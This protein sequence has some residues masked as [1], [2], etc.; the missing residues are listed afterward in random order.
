MSRLQNKIAVITGSTRGFGYAL[1]AELL[2][3]GVKV[4]V[5]GRTQPAV[6]KA[7]EELRKLGVLE[8]LTCDVSVPEQVYAL[9]RFAA[10]KFGGLDIWVNNAGYTTAAGG[11]IDFPPEEALTTLE[12][13]CLGTLNG[14]Q[15]ALAVMLPRRQGTLV[16]LYGRGS[17]LKPASP[18]GLYGATKAWITSFTRTLAAENKGQGIQIVGFSPGMMR[19]SMLEVEEVVGER[20]QAMM[21]NMPMVYE[22]LA[23]PPQEPAAELV[24][25][26]E[27]NQKEFV[28]Y[29]YLRGLRG[30]AMI[31]QLVWMQMNPKARP[32]PA[33]YPHRPAFRPPVGPD[34]R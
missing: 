28:E 20:V 16:N 34:L 33:D 1:A 25:L 29:R 13:N 27:T 6:D 15:A 23:R 12:T 17:D 18:S 22:A 24:R 2:K 26:L 21:R 10:E 32:A 31:A 11:I 4:V 3:A 9:A 8:G 14:T 30:F 7:A 5:S 19:T